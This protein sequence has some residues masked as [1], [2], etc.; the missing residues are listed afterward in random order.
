MPPSLIHH[1]NIKWR[2]QPLSVTIK[3]M[4]RPPS[5]I[6]GNWQSMVLFHGMASR[7]IA[8]LSSMVFHNPWY[9]LKAHC[10]NVIK[11]LY[12]FSIK[13]WRI[14]GILH[15]SYSIELLGYW[16]WVL[17]LIWF[18]RWGSKNHLWAS[19]PYVGY[20]LYVCYSMLQMLTI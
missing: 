1:K 10:N 19:P 15:F 3:V 2:G 8:P 12:A 4:E 11:R 16:F 7:H 13:H 5:L 6:H 20:L 14:F 9:F 18:E 17:F